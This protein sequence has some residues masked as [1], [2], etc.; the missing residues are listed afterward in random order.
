MMA[1]IVRQDL[2]RKV[3]I[4][5]GGAQGIGKAFSVAFLQRGG[6]V[7]IG[8]LQ[9]TVGSDTCSELQ[10][11]FGK[12]NVAFTQV[13]VTDHDQ[14]DEMYRLTLR[15]FSRLDVVVN[16]AGVGFEV[17]NSAPDWWRK[18]V[19]I[20]LTALIDSTYLAKYYMSS[21]KGGSGGVVVNIASM[22]GLQAMPFSP[23]Y[24]ASKHGVIGFTRAT[25]FWPAQY[26]VSVY[27]I[28][29]GFV[30]TDMLKSGM[31]N[32]AFSDIVQARGV[33]TPERIAE[34]FIQLLDE[35]PDSGQVMRV[36]VQKGID[37]Q[38]YRVP[39]AKL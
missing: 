2:S 6:K 25:E 29:P 8:D 27:A 39:K 16:N 11:K 38:K 9:P 32:E 7:M 23:T 35:R 3:A 14:L 24:S 33:L 4:I 5:T 30:Q 34:G 1:G 18:T 17:E 26:G 12:A 31:E 22:G 10:S 28:C 15:K 20:N 21:E 36:T 19:A 13:D 37:Y